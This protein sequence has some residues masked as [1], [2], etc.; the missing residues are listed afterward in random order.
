MYGTSQCR[1]LQLPVRSLL[2]ICTALS[3]WLSLFADTHFLAD[4]GGAP[5]L[6][7]CSLGEPSYEKFN[8]I[9][10]PAVSRRTIT[11]RYTG[12]QV[13][14]ALAAAAARAGL[15]AELPVISLACAAI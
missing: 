5:G 6:E 15:A 13:P 8:I 7:R 2:A 10:P 1:V 14:L 4:V 12:R 3:L 11:G 9:C